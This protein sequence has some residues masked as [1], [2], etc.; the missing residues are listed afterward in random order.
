M[1]WLDAQHEAAIRALQRRVE[2]AQRMGATKTARML[3]DRLATAVKARSPK[4]VEE[5]TRK[6]H[7]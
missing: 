5:L 3:A 1:N 7:P 6:N 4:A 2:D